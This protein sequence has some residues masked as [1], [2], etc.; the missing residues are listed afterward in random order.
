VFGSKLASDPRA[1]NAALCAPISCPAG[2]MPDGTTNPCINCETGCKTC[3]APEAGHCS[4]IMDGYW[5]D[6]A[7]PVACPAGCKT[8]SSAKVCTSCNLFL[9]LG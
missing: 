8:C 5:L 7:T 1:A 4:A 9:A 6:T 3:S 2:E